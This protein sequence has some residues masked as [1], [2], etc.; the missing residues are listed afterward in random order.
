MRTPHA[1]QKWPS[2][3]LPLSATRVK[4]FSV[5]CS[6]VRASLRTISDMAN[7]LPVCRWQAV[8]WQTTSPSGSPAMR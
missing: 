7:A 1:G 4:D 6:R 5:P 8:Q 2:S 3:L